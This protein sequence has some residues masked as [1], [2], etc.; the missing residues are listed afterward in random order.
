MIKKISI[1]LSYLALM[2]VVMLLSA[3]PAQAQVEI[4][5][6]VDLEFSVGEE[7]SNFLTNEIATEYRRAHAAINQ[8]NLFAFA[9]VSDEFSFAARVQF[10]TWGAGRLNPPRLTLATVQ[11]QPAESPLSLQAGRFITPFGLFSRR[12]LAA[13]NLFV[14]YPM[15][16]DYFINLSDRRGLWSQAGNTGA[17]GGSDDVGI[18]TLYFGGYTTG[19]AANLIFIPNRLNLE[20]ALTNASLASQVDY[21]NLSN[22][23]V[24]A[25]LGFQPDIVWQQGISVSYG[26][27]MQE[28]PENA[29][30][31]NLN[32]YTQLA[33]GTDLILA[34]L[35]FELSGEFVYSMWRVPR[36][37]SEALGTFEVSN[38]GGYADLKLEPPF[39]TGSYLAFRYER[40]AFTPYTEPVTA[41]KVRWDND[42]ARYSVAAG[43]KFARNVLLK[44]AYSVQTTSSVAID[45]KDNA[46]RSILTVSF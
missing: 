27:F 26:G 40:L 14:N 18:T 6:S 28:A 46:F 1:P 20:L 17:Y 8:F 24:V 16:Y 34:Y 21:T 37:N 38:F 42:V 12:S 15:L 44:L 29:A 3:T 30:L 39:L 31:S 5:G 11:W 33:V 25:R 2:Y 45:P 4:S 23:A 13:D 7:D 9:K 43:Y 32:Q 36:F 19:I 22:L 10:D 41:Q 35:Y